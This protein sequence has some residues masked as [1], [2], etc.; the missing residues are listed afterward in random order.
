MELKGGTLNLDLTTPGGNTAPV[1]W[2]PSAAPSPAVHGKAFYVITEGAGLGDNVKKFPLAGDETV[3]DAISQVNGLSQVS[4]RKLWVAR[5]SAKDP[6]KGTVLPVD[7]EAITQR[8]IDATNYP[9]LPGDRVFIAE[10]HL[11]AMNNKLNKNI[12][13]V[14]RLLGLVSLFEA[15]VRGLML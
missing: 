5:P 14:E 4:S 7:W 6:K 13:P 2:P 12:A 9:L 15:T 10:D 3:L 8:G 11:V 1:E